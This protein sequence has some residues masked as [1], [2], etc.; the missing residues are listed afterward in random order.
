MHAVAVTEIAKVI[1]AQHN[2][3]GFRC[4]CDARERCPYGFLS[5]CLANN[6]SSGGGNEKSSIYSG[7]AAA[8]PPWLIVATRV[9]AE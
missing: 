9:R 2:E 8:S 7:K 6:A 1:V 3:H 4:V 5:R